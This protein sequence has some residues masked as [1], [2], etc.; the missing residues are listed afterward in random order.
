M[1]FLTEGKLKK[2]KYK[3]ALQIALQVFPSIIQLVP[4]CLPDVKTSECF[5]VLHT[6]FL[7]ALSVQSLRKKK[8]VEMGRVYTF[9]AIYEADRRR[10][11]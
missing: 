4:N 2:G 1:F 3:N 7:V 8:A 10:K 11:K 9:Q 5:T 6:V